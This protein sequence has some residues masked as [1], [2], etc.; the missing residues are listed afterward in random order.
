MKT[1]FLLLASL[2]FLV[3]FLQGC[4]GPGHSLKPSSA[5]AGKSNAV[6]AMGPDHMDHSQ[7][8]QHMQHGHH[9]MTDMPG[10]QHDDQS[11]G[12]SDHMGHSDHS[13]SSQFGGH[14]QSMAALGSGTA[15]LPADSPSY[16]WHFTLPGLSDQV[17]QNC[18]AHGELK[19]SFDHQGGPRG[20]SRWQSQNWLMGSCEFALS[21][22]TAFFVRGMITLEPFTS[23]AGG[24][25]QL[26]Q[27]G[28]TYRGNEIV[29]AQHPHNLISEL[30]VG[31]TQ[32]L[33]EDLRY[34]FYFGFP[35]DRE[36]GP[37]AFMHRPSA[38]DNPAVPLCHHCQDA[39]HI[40][41][42]VVSDRKSVV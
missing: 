40:T 12:D 23:P 2:S 33:T 32:R 28:E 26:F 1:K 5:E 22:D 14:Y 15:L 18:M 30:A 42:G 20:V 29:D 11:N 38:L 9:N 3:A 35:G 6:A 4:A 34:Y 39:G 8:M 27:S 31:F 36:E 41:N 21:G 16:M 37:T 10:M 17:K 13:M 24:F 7:H 19:L 25:P